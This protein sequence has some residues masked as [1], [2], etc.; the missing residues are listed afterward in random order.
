MLIS[1]AVIFGILK[2]LFRASILFPILAPNSTKDLIEV[3]FLKTFL[4]KNITIYNF[5]TTISYKVLITKASFP[6]NFL[7][8]INFF[9]MII[10]LIHVLK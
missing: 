4:K 5:F 10:K 9:H 1:T 8:I 7:R 3:F 2:I 6:K